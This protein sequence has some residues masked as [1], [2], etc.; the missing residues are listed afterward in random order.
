MTIINS[1]S[2]VSGLA[3]QEKYGS[4]G[5]AGGRADRGR[6]RTS[7]TPSGDTVQISSEAW[8]LFRS[9]ANGN[10][11]ASQS[12]A[13][14]ENG[15]MNS[16]ED[17]GGG[18]FGISGGGIS[19]RDQIGQLESEISGLQ[20]EIAALEGQ[21]ETDEL[22]ATIL[23]SKLARLQLLQSELTGLLAKSYQIS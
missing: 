13:T 19:V 3:V 18:T 2:L 16:S 9:Q 7:V 20:G 4:S 14:P 1:A 23:R 6:A 15:R 21:A 22:A 8:A 11:G 5:V 10:T 17:T 12:S